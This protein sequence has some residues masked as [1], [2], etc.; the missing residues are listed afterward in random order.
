MNGNI[1]H[2]SQIINKIVS[3]VS[4]SKSKRYYDCSK[5][6]FRISYENI[7]CFYDQNFKIK[8]CIYDEDFEKEVMV[9]Y[10]SFLTPN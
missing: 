1:T 2:I 9:I 10:K 6:S 7:I 8:T 4:K 5:V 3:L